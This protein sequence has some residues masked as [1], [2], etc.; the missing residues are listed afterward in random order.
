MNAAFALTY[1][2]HG[3]VLLGQACD[4]LLSNSLGGCPYRK[5]DPACKKPGAI[6]PG[7]SCL[8]VLCS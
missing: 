1:S 2:P 8:S 3:G 7:R 4:K 5:P 6:C